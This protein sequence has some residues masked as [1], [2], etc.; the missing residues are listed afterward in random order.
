M[1]ENQPERLK[2][3]DQAAIAGGKP[4]REKRL[5]FNQP[6]LNPADAEQVAA[7]VRSGRLA[8]GPK[9]REFEERFA[10]LVGVRYAV[11]VS[12]ET[13][14]LHAAY[15]AAGISRGDEVIVSPFV[16]PAVGSALL[17]LGAKPVFADVDERTLKIDPV[18]IERN[19]AE[20]TRAVVVSHFAG[21]PCDIEAVLAVARKHRLTV[22]EDATEAL[23]AFYRGRPVGSFSVTAA[24]GFQ[25]GAAITTGKGG[26]VVTDNEDAHGWLRLFGDQGI[27]R[28]IAQLVRIE[29]PWHYEVQELGYDYRPTE[30]QAALGLSQLSRL[31]T[32]LKRRREIAARY[33]EAFAD[34]PYLETPYTSPDSEPAWNLYVL[35]LNLE[36]L[37]AGR[38]EIFLALLGEGISVGV[39]YLP[40]YLHPLYGWLGDPTVCTLHQGPPCPKAEAVYRRLITLPLYPKMSDADVEDVI[41]AVRRVLIYFA[42]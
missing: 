7:V 41:T 28:D 9:V 20:N 40:V 6:D 39:H 30:M 36:R 37:R 27:V 5:P 17:Y 24:F 42:K 21:F 34:L 26:M 11:A 12:S 16:S 32:L 13:A 23:G 35:R 3:A 29:G 8:A 22:V 19:V 31:E 2:T 18:E 10:A 38:R 1:P 33:N 25:P 15:Y 14:A 4:V